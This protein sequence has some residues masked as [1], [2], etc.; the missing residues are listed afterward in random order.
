MLSQGRHVSVVVP[1]FKGDTGAI[2]V[3]IPT[4]ECVFVC[5]K[6]MERAG[7]H[8]NVNIITETITCSVFLYASQGLFERDK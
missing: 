7:W 5:N 8:D 2:C 3:F 4:A 6:T 1:E